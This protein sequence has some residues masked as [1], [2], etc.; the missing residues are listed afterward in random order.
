MTYGQEAILEDHAFKIE[1]VVA[2]A[3]SPKSDITL[4]EIVAILE[5]LKIIY[6]MKKSKVADMPPNVRRHWREI[7]A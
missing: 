2:L 7:D 1:P 4:V 3:F 6:H 5:S